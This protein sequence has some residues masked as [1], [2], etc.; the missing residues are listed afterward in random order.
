MDIGSYGSNWIESTSNNENLIFSTIVYHKDAL[1]EPNGS[2]TQS[3]DTERTCG[4][5]FQM[6]IHQIRLSSGVSRVCIEK[7]YEEETEGQQKNELRSSTIKRNWRIHDETNIP[8]NPSSQAYTTTSVASILVSLICEKVRPFKSN[9]AKLKTFWNVCEG[10]PIWGNLPP[11]YEKYGIS[12][13][14]TNFW[15]DL[16]F[17][18]SSINS[19]MLHQKKQPS[20]SR[21]KNIPTCFLT[22]V[23]IQQEIM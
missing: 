9:R 17:F 4:W 5:R 12:R 10:S 11:N 19:L 1:D 22:R 16:C 8:L 3:S 2:S 21:W 20:L 23:R 7:T 6:L 15:H 13:Q 14:T 18:D